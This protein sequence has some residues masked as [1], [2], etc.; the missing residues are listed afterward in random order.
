MTRASAGVVMVERRIKAGPATVFAYFTDPAKWLRWQRI[1]AT[2]EP[3]PG[4]VFRMN[5]RG[6]GF[7]SGRFV[8]ITPP[9]RGPTRR[10][11]AS[12]APPL[13]QSGQ[14]GMAA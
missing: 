14:L 4:G 7:A 1:E 13:V 3:W 5:V 10:W 12:S 6:D 2:I 8:E 11:W 9:V